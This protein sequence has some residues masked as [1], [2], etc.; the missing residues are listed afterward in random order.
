[1]NSHKDCNISCKFISSSWLVEEMKGIFEFNIEHARGSGSGIDILVQWF[2]VLKQEAVCLLFP[3]EPEFP[4][5]S[6]IWT[7]RHIS[8]LFDMKVKPTKGLRISGKIKNL[9]P[10][11]NIDTAWYA[12]MA[13]NIACIEGTA[14]AKPEYQRYQSLK[15]DLSSSLRPWWP[16]VGS[17]HTHCCRASSIS[18]GCD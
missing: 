16:L 12:V 6:R 8:L 18:S 5:L 13:A 10:V 14:L 17:C 15:E 1:M 11:P 4:L 9:R 3:V 7:A 2:P